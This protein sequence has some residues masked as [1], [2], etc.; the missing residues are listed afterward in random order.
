MFG[1][2]PCPNEDDRMGDYTITTTLGRNSP[3]LTLDDELW[4]DERFR[5]AEESDEVVKD[6]EVKI[7]GPNI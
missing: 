3:P 1:K 4:W 7:E 2:P 6:T 5:E